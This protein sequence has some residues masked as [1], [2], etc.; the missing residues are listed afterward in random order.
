MRQFAKVA[1]LISTSLALAAQARGAPT[2]DS[3]PQGSPSELSARLR[4]E[5]TRMGTAKLSPLFTILADPNQRRELR[6]SEQQLDFARQLEAVTRDIIRAWLIRDLD[7]VPH[8]PGSELARRIGE[9]GERSRGRLISH[10]EAIALQGI[11]TPGQGRTLLRAVG[12]KPAALLPGRH[13]VSRMMAADEERPATELAEALRYRTTNFDRAGL[14]SLILL[15]RPGVRALYPNGIAQEDPI[16][17]KLLREQ[18]MPKVDLSN[19]QAELAERL[20][21]LTLAVWRSWVTRD[22]EQVPLPPQRVLA[23]RLW[24]GGDRLR[25][26]LFGQAEAVMLEGVAGPEQAERALSEVWRLVELR[27]LLDPMLASRLRLSRSQRDEVQELL[28]RKEDIVEDTTIRVGSMS[29]LIPSRPDLQQQ[30][31]QLVQETKNR[32][33]ELDALIWEVLRPSQAL[34]LVRILGGPPAERG[35]AAKGMRQKRPG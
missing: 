1:V 33:D 21:A 32:Q 31:Q 16:H 35:Q 2:D 25:D 28:R 14:V 5:A 13:G 22:L 20:D 12:Q 7:E 30:A 26:S 19:E 34:A 11:L 15:G 27:A 9:Q 18:Y 23:Q 24:E 8:P 3:V 17:Q 10:A 4:D 6:L 29:G